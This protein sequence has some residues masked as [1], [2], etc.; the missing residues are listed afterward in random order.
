MPTDE[1]DVY[2]YRGHFDS[3]DAVAWSP[4]G[5]RIVSASDDKTVQ[6]WDASNGGN[7]FTYHGHSTCVCRRLVA[8]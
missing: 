4:D 5:K 8:R 2:R 3:C 6:V 7:V 1:G